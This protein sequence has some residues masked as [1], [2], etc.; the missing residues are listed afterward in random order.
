MSE[1]VAI[2]GLSGAGRSQAAA[3]LEDLGWFVIDNVP[4]ELIPKLA[5]L[6]TGPG[7]RFDRVVLVVR[8]GDFDDEVRPAL[9]RLRAAAA[10][11]R[12]VFLDAGTDVLVRRYEDTRR[13]HPLASSAEGDRSVAVAIDTERALLEPLKEIADVVIDTGA[14]NV[15]Q[16]RQRVVGLFGADSPEVGLRVNMVSFGFKRGLPLDVDMV[17]DL[18]FLPNPHWVDELRPLTGCDAPVREFVLGQPDTSAFL[19]RVRDLLDFLLPRY[20][21]EGKSYLSLALGCT[22]GRHRSV[23]VAEEL[24]VHARD[25]GFQ[26]SVLH[27]DVGR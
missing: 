8:S 24:A 25:L 7:S 9:E 22:G 4:A 26:V 6:T 12:I 17:L 3:H 5:E 2:C 11:V 23:A 10:R 21:A 16:L 27:R 19:S 15:H 18:R 1:F 13:R 14:L 20:A